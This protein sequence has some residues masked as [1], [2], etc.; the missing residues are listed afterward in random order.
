LKSIALILLFILPGCAT[1]NDS[2]TLGLG[3]GTVTGAAA[4]FAGFAAG[5]RPY[6]FENIAV[7]SG[8]GAAV[9]LVTS[10]FTHK[11]VEEDRKTYDNQTFEQHFGDLPPSPFIIPKS[12]IKKGT[13]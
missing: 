13:R 7:G 5:D 3:I 6:T 9:G 2:L 12:K 4:T 1:L 10:Y 8:I 11:K